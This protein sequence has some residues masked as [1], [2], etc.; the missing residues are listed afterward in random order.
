L[1]DA[2]V[3]NA[4][5]QK[6]TRLVISEPMTFWGSLQWLFP[7][8]PP[9]DTVHSPKHLGA[10]HHSKLPCPRTLLFQHRKYF[11]YIIQNYWEQAILKGQLLNKKEANQYK[12]ITPLIWYSRKDK[13]T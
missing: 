13:F 2:L 11:N 10:L 6:E 3:K 1:G 9:R 8:S 12:Y 7:G 4:D 5:I